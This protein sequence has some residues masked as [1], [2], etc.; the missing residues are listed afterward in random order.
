MH[1]QSMICHPKVGGLIKK[2][3]LEKPRHQLSH[4]EVKKCINISCNSSFWKSWPLKKNDWKNVEKHTCCQIVAGDQD[5]WSKMKDMHYV[6]L[7]TRVP[8]LETEKVLGDPI[9][10]TQGMALR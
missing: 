5:F 7:Q 6:F 4:R 2:T 9:Q 1:L 3:H 8:R 10:G